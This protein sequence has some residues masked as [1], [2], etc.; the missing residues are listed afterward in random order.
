MFLGG[1]MA[2]DRLPSMNHHPKF[3]IREEALEAGVRTEV[4]MAL[5]DPRSTPAYD[6][7]P[8]MNLTSTQKGI[9]VTLVPAAPELPGDGAASSSA[10]AGTEEGANS[11]AKKDVSILDAWKNRNSL[12]LGLCLLLNNLVGVGLL[13]WL[14]TM[15]SQQFWIT[16]AGWQYMVVILGYGLSLWV[17]T[18]TG[19]GVVKKWFENNEKVFMLIMSVIGAELMI[20]AVIIPNL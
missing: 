7:H 5:N 17:A 15:Y 13:T 6:G 18:S 16:P 9:F 2:E 1:G 10:A 3:G 14:A 4:Q 12:V 11:S 20:V 19:P 8:T